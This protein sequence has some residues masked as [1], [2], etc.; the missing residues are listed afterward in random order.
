[1]ILEDADHN[2]PAAYIHVIHNAAVSM[3]VLIRLTV[4]RLLG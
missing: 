1:M 4:G 3:L 2:L